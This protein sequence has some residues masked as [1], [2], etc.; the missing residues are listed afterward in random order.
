[1]SSVIVKEKE[2][3]DSGFRRF[4]RICAKAGFDLEIRM[5]EH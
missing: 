2:T 1:M 4:L 5:R 3:L